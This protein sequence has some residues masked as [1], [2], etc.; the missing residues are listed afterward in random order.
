MLP[1]MIAEL[2]LTL[3]AGR[4]SWSHVPLSIVI[5]GDVLLGAGFAVTTW[6]QAVNRF[7]EPGVRIQRERGQHVIEFGTLRNRPPPRL[8]RCALDI[9]GFSAGAGI[10]VGPDSGGL[11]GALILGVADEP[12]GHAASRR[13]RRL[14]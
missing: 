8:F 12:R 1:A 3:D 14:R 2:P 5:L 4:L 13:A 10:V 11:G 7:F 9:C 6:A